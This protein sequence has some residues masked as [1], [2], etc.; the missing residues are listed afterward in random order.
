MAVTVADVMR[1]VR[2]T[3]PGSCMTD[4]WRITDGSLTP[5]ALLLPGDWIAIR[6]SML[7]DGIWQLQDGVTL[8]GAR[9]EAFRGEVWLLQPPAEFLSLCAE[10]A[11]WA[12]RNRPDAVK[13]ER[14][15]DYGCTRALDRNG[16]P[17]DWRD[18]FRARLIPYRRMFGEVGLSC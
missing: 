9:D 1:E 16:L 12:A 3:F 17:V 13:S 8:P 6:G 5:S 14:F 18:V 10:I 2:N 4:A 11:G 15:G 7:N